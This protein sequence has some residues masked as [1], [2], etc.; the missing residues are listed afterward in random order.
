MTNLIHFLRLLQRNLKWMFV[1]AFIMAVAV[2]FFTRDMPKEY[3]SETEIFTGITSGMSIDNMDGAKMDFFAAN[4]AFDNLINIIKSR[5]T[6]EEVGMRLLAEHLM[7]DTP[8]V[9]IIS[10]NE[11]LIKYKS[12]KQK[13]FLTFKKLSQNFNLFIFDKYKRL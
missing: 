4:N 13:N 1:M 5:Q 12:D 9:N 3:Q 2:F 7:I 11:N 8:T 10:N 6:I